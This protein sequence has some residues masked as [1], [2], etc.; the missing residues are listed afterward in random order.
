MGR[1]L[2]VSN[3]LPLQL[4]I[5]RGKLR[6]Q[7]TVGGLATGLGSFYRSYESAWL[8]WYETPE[9]LTETKRKEL[10]E[11]LAKE[12]SCYPVFLPEAIAK[13]YYDGFCNKTLWPLFHDFP[14]F[15]E[16]EDQAWDAYVE[17]N[18]IFADAVVAQA[19]P[20]DVIWVHDYHLMLLPQLLRD[21]L[22]DATIG[23]FL[24]IPFPP[25]E[26][27][28]TLPWREALLRGLLGA[29]LIGFHTYDYVQYFLDCVHRLFGYSNMLGRI[30]T[31]DRII[32]ADA[33]P[34]G[35]D[36]ERFARA[37]QQSGVRREVQRISKR[38]H[39]HKLVL[40]VDRMD[41]TKGIPERLQA[42]ECL[43]EEHPEYR[44]KVTLILVAV[45]TRTHVDH[46]QELKRDVDELVGR[47]NG[48]YGSIDWMPVWYL[49]RSVP[50]ATLSAFYR[51]ADVCL[52]TALRDGMNL[53]AKEYVASRTD[54]RGVLV[55]SETAG[56]SKELGEALAI[57]A[58]DK[59]G[60]AEAIDQALQMPEDEQEN[61]MRA[62]QERLQHFDVHRWAEDFIDSL[63]KVKDVQSDLERRRLTRRTRERLMEDYGEA[64]RRLLLLDY[65]GTLV[66]FVD[67]PNQARPDADLLETL[68]QL[69]ED[70]RN[71][72]VVISGRDRMSLEQWLGDLPLEL[73][74][75]HGAWRREPDGRWM[76]PE[77]WATDW[78]ADLRPVLD[79][80]VRRTPGT[81]LEEKEFSL[82]WH[83][84]FADPVLGSAR[85]LE[86]KD[87]LVHMVGN[88]GLEVFD[89]NKV[90]EVKNQRV[91]KGYATQELLSRDKWDFV[92]ALG[93]DRTDEDTFATVPDEGY[94]VKIGYGPSLAKYN[95]DSVREARRLI[96]DLAGVDS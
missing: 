31:E 47:I 70:K 55:L 86:L 41:Y 37:E 77:D 3:R 49:F 57:N 61:R 75:E 22:P 40:S 71:L 24:H 95:L 51:S 21:R 74:S 50:F 56:S 81:F 8:G 96:H 92:L 88:L 36:Y 12:H 15:T 16:I 83:Y 90:L 72:V 87:A 13:D 26:L 73:I 19:E 82:A 58:H 11:Y 7:P 46:Y 23:W 78:K 65:D 64:H 79:L 27:F 63:H 52:I 35:I 53:V 30:T 14:Q 84:R 45:P 93:D 60:T 28:R 54:G 39:G 5:K 34:M 1:L 85:A 66:G 4:E 2:I 18:R 69:A 89:G 76:T 48:K 91:S 17:A 10:S 32:K 6:P 67:R 68:Q 80:Y 20:G 62:M 44:E 29:D 33:F 43:L 25:F 38:A 9:Q 94:T 59:R 42:F